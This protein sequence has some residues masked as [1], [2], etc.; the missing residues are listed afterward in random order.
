MVIK[1]FLSESTAFTTP[2][3]LPSWADTSPIIAVKTGANAKAKTVIKDFGV[4]LFYFDTLVVQLA[5]CLHP[6]HLSTIE[7]NQQRGGR[8][9]SERVT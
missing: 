5:P 9:C 3:R 4:Q 2:C 8:S 1:V 7:E 6:D